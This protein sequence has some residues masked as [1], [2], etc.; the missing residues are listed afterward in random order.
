MYISSATFQLAFVKSASGLQD[1]HSRTLSAVSCNG[2]SDL[3]Q[4][5]SAGATK[6]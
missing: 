4:L 2:Q 1:P 6:Q 5:E 3:V